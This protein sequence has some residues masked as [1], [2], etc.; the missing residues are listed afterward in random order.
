VTLAVAN[1]LQRKVR[2]AVCIL[3]VGI[4][5]AL[6]LV[7]VG[8]TRGSIQEV[9]RRIENVGGDI[10]VQPAGATQFLAL[11]SGILPEKYAELLGRVPG[12]AAVS[13]VVTWTTTFG[14][15]F[16]VVYGIDPER[17]SSIG[18]GLRM[19]EGRALR[20]AGEVVVDSRL[21]SAAR[22]AVGDRME[23]LGSSFE[24]VG[25]SK[26]GVGA[27]IFLPIRELQSMLHQEDRVSLFFVRCA[28]P[29]VVKATAAAIEAALKGVRCQI[30]EG[31][32][33]EMARSMTGLREFIGAIT[34][35]TLVVSLLVVALAMYMTI[36]EKTREIGILRSLGASR[37]TIMGNVVLESVLL[38]GGGVIAGYGLTIGAVAALRAWY[39][40][41]N[42]EITPYW[43]VVAGGLGLASG[44]LGALYPAWF[45]ARQ[46]PV[47]ALSYE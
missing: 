32:A 47:R 21:A 40:L 42:V 7:L 35:T 31:F 33:D 15:G 45:A 16:Y 46:D 14:N 5:I 38:T 37:A 2:S 18:G 10:I 44:L 17:F 6:L 19:V 9:A 27:R 12:V 20:G 39:P 8:M 41:L 24:V 34:G 30:L 28:S 25:V 11:K 3:A 29:A 43:I 26:E 36:L 1:V 23:L 22:L 4:G 13:P